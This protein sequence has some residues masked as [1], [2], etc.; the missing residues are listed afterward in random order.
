[1]SFSSLCYFYHVVFVFDVIIF[2]EVLLIYDVIFI[3]K[4]V[5]NFQA[6]SNFE[7]VFINLSMALL[8][9]TKKS[10][11]KSGFPKASGS[12]NQ[13]AQLTSLKKCDRTDRQIDTQHC[14]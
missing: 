9:Q 5:F 6:V 7:V 1:M 8:S 10:Q 2:F 11:E 3:L 12:I 4:F 14:S 13:R